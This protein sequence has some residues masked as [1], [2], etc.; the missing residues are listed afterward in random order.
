MPLIKSY[1]EVSVVLALNKVDQYTD[2][3]IL[4]IL[5][6]VDVSFE[7][8][9]VANGEQCEAVE[10]VLLERYGK[11]SFVRFF[12]TPIPQLT[13]ALNFAVSQAKAD[14]I[15][16]MDADDIS[17]AS[18]LRLQLDYMVKNNLDVLGS[19]VILIDENGVALGE[20]SYPSGAKINKLLPFRNCFCHPSVI[21]K[22]DIF[23]KVRGYNAGFNSED[24]D[25]WL[26]LMRLGVRWDNIKAPL[27]LY[28][29]H[30]SSAQGTRL[31]Y[32]ECAGLAIREFFMMK[33]ISSFI[34]IFVHAI[35]FLYKPMR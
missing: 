9:L 20:R 4:S 22:K 17:T 33:K 19:D 12:S 26:R 1:P 14:Y 29:V 10:R 21:F 18:R 5:E 2:T 15:A 13:Y 23:Y 16:R 28:R 30:K 11:F 6:Q 34:A 24:Y 27:L 8:I 32:A 31:A 25:L 35:K 7:L 3:A